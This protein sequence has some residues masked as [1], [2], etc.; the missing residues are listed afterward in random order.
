MVYHGISSIIYIMV[1]TSRTIQHHSWILQQDPDL[2]GLL[3]RH[4]SELE[5]VGFPDWDDYVYNRKEA[6]FDTSMY[7]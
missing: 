1:E 7:V 2:Q 6:C 5:E 3:Q 4:I